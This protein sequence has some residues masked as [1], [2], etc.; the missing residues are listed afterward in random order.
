MS[1]IKAK[2]L[3]RQ[4]NSQL[5]DSRPRFRKATP[6]LS[7]NIQTS[8]KSALSKA[9]VTED[10]T[11]MLKPNNRVAKTISCNSSVKNVTQGSGKRQK[12]NTAK[13]SVT[14]QTNTTTLTRQ[15]TLEQLENIAII[16]KCMKYLKDAEKYN[17]VRSVD[18][19]MASEDYRADQFA[20]LQEILEEFIYFTPSLQKMLFNYRR[21]YLLEQEHMSREITHMF[22]TGEFDPAVM[23]VNERLKAVEDEEKIKKLIKETEVKVPKI[24]KINLDKYDEIIENAINFLK[25]QKKEIE[26]RKKIRD[27]NLQTAQKAL[28]EER[29]DRIR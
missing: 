9:S 2:A 4:S 26:V 7:R 29:L 12:I 24:K 21:S 13:T 3:H 15:K 23:I 17:L 11:P 14:N 16:H 19:D 18:I 6:K 22:C 8:P 25:Q 28:Q 1:Q 27:Q 10:N 20:Q 5:N